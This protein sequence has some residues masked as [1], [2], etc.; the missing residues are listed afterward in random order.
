MEKVA[1]SWIRLQVNSKEK[2]L[3]VCRQENQVNKPAPKLPD[4]YQNT[5]QSVPDDDLVQQAL[6]LQRQLGKEKND[7]I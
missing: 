6:S 2:A 4:W 1:A 3:E 7:E 5:E